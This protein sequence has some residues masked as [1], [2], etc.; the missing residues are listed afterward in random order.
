MQWLADSSGSWAGESTL[1]LSWL[2]EDQRLHAGP[3]KM[4]IDAIG[5]H[6]PFRL[7]YDWQY[8][9]ATQ[10]GEMLIA[11]TSPTTVAL[12]WVDS[13]HQGADVMRLEGPLTDSMAAASGTYQVEG[14]PAWGWRIEIEL[15][16]DTLHFRMFN[17]SPEGDEEWAVRASYKRS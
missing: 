6:G 15:T 14:H 10:R 16:G 5:D 8:E 11:G 7:A 12:G 1:H 2:P 17:I 13:W 9:G 4:Q 3:S